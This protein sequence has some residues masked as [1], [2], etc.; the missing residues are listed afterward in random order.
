[1]D[2]GEEGRH[3]ASLSAG[4]FFLTVEKSAMLPEERSG[5]ASVR[6]WNQ[7]ADNTG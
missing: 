3:R 7:V 1:M 2:G 5:L 6:M 4:L